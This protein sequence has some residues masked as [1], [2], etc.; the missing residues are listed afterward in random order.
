MRAVLRDPEILILDEATA[1]ID[2]V[3]EQLLEQILARAAAVDD[4]GRS[5]RTG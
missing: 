5:S 1:N 2:T 4:Q 3:T